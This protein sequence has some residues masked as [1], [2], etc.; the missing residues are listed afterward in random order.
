MGKERDSTTWTPS[1]LVERYIGENILRPDTLR[2][3]RNAVH[4]FEK[5]MGTIRISEI[6][7]KCVLKWRSKILD[8]ARPTTWNNYRLHLGVVW[9][10]AVRNHWL[11]KNVFKEVRPAPVLKKAKKTVSDELLATTISYL[12]DPNKAPRPAWFWEI[13]VR[14][15]YFTGMRRRQLTFLRWKHIDFKEHTILLTAEGNKTKRDWTIPIPKNCLKDLLQLRQRTKAA[16]K[17]AFDPNDQVFRVQLFYDRYAGKELSP[18]Q[19]GGFF[20]RL[21]NAL[22]GPVSS[23]RLRHT[24]ATELAKG[25]NRDLKLLQHVLG[26]TNLSTTLEYVHPEPEQFRDFLNQLHLPEKPGD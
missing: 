13:V 20:K 7:R 22:S 19:V 11:E 21:S 17:Q 16:N 4:V 26:H 5:D 15:L 1:Q 9:N 8:R 2:N 23:H 10:F 14:L 25:P 12:Q 24:M 3:Y 18:G 6:D